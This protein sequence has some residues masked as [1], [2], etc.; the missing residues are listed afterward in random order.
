MKLLT[1]LAVPTIVWASMNC[2]S[3]LVRATWILS[4]ITRSWRSLPPWS[5]RGSPPRMPKAPWYKSAELTWR[6]DS[7]HPPDNTKQEGLTMQCGFFHTPY[8][9]P[10]RTAREMFDWCSMLAPFCD[11]AGSTAFIIGE[12]STLAWETIPYPAII[13]G[14]AAP[15]TGNIRFA[16]LA[17]P[18]PSHTPASLAI[19]IGWLSR[20]LQGRYFLGVA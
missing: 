14:A 2:F 7:L 18:L 20:V 3:C 12:R 1:R 19:R 10:H 11:L 9:L 4:R 8:N 6:P 15:L 5:R 13:I 17:H 16:P